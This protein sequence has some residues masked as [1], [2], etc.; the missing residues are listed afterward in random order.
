MH[1]ETKGSLA[2]MGE[3][4]ST[5]TA[6]PAGDGR[7]VWLASYPKSGNT[8]FRVFCS[9]LR[10]DA[11][12]PVDINSLDRTPIAA[13]AE[14]FEDVTG[15]SAADLTDNELLNLRPSVYDHLSATLDEVLMCKTHDANTITPAGRRLHSPLATRSAIYFIRNPLDVA[16]SYA[17]HIPTDPD[18]A[19][20]H[21]ADPR[22]LLAGRGQRQVVQ[23][24]L[25]W[26]GHVCSWVDGEPEP[27]VVRY[28]DMHARPLET[29]TAASAH[30]GFPTDRARVEKALRFS[31]F[32]RLRSQEERSGFFEKAPR[33]TS[34]FRR[35]VVDAW[36]DELTD[37]QVDR[38]IGDHY[39]V[40]LRFGYLHEDG[41]P[42]TDVGATGGLALA[43]R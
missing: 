32:E 5:A 42:A 31:S 20:G 19:I 2:A 12:E 43:P 1:N 21:M 28:E 14:L 40:M 15:T 36:R 8:W 26:S 22:H 29:F 23:H 25:T 27:M 9:N 17:H 4:V 41:R 3:G 24:L 33:A 34:F 7:V 16:V 13:S 39:A 37:A 10:A 18:T 30:A 35:G 38:I 11:D 6:V